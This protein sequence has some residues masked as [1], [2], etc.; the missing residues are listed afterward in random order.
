M[1]G[2]SVAQSRMRAG[3]LPPS[4]RTV[5]VRDRAAE[6]ATCC[7]TGRDPMNV[8]CAMEGCEVRW[9]AVGGQQVMGWIRWGEWLLARR[10]ERAMLVK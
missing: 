2:R 1:A 7:A 9:E 3:S 10:A 4:S 5:G 8:R 6:R